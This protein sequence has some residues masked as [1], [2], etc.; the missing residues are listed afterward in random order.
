MFYKLKESTSGA[1]KKKTAECNGVE[2]VS[3]GQ[4]LVRF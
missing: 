3:G 2:K 1:Q 4:G